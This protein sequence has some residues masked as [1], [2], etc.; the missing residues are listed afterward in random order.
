[1]LSAVAMMMLAILVVEMLY[2]VVSRRVFSAPTLWAYDLAYMLN[3]LGFIL[4]AGYAL[5]HNAHIRIDFLSTRLPPRV[6]DALNVGV[7]VLLV[8]PAMTV[9]VIGA[10]DEFVE[11]WV[12]DETDPASPWRPLLWPLFSGILIGFS[13]FFLQI[14]AE[15]VRHALAMTGRGPSP[16]GTGDGKTPGT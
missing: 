4:A 13:A 8:F 6:Q 5:R 2:E 14:V 16:L 9:L 1:M 10:F 12:T 3:G 15:C 11:A 7:Y